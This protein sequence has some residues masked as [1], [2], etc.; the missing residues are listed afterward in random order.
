MTNPT[1]LRCG[2]FVKNDYRIYLWYNRGDY[3]E[4]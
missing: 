4:N 1:P 3:E 2:D